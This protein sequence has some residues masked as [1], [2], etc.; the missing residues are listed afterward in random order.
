MQ[1][2]ILLLQWVIEPIISFYI[3]AIVIFFLF[4]LFPS[5]HYLTYIEARENPLEKP[6]LDIPLLIKLWL[7]LPQLLFWF[8]LLGHTQQCLGLLLFL[9]WE[10]SGGTSGTRWSAGYWTQFG[11]VQGKFHTCCF[12]SKALAHFLSSSQ[13]LTRI[14][15]ALPCV[16]S[17]TFILSQCSDGA[18]HQELSPSIVPY[19]E[20]ASPR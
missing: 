1:R 2:R 4:S 7:L 12:I 5:P 17:R 19:P 14:W 3:T 6:H 9:H 18:H 11:E 20:G 13:R 10:H 15:L 8:F 16:S